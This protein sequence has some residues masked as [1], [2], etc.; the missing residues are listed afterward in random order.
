MKEETEM[1]EH[2]GIE[3]LLATYRD[4]GDADR[5]RVDRH[6][7]S[8][9]T[10]AARLASY[11][12]QDQDLARLADAHPSSRLRKDFYAAIGTRGEA[13]PQARVWSLAGQMAELAVVIL[14]IAVLGFVL[15]ERLH[16]M[17][18]PAAA[19]APEAA[20]PAVLQPS[21]APSAALPEV[22]P[23]APDYLAAP[24]KV[25]PAVE[26]QPAPVML[27]GNASVVTGTTATQAGEGQAYVVRLD[28]SLWKLAEKYLGD[29]NRYGEIVQAT[30]AKHAEDASFASVE[31]P[32]VIQP[33]SKLWIP[34]AGAQ[35]APVAV[36]AA[37]PAVPP[38]AAP[39][40]KP[41]G[42]P[43]LATGPAGQIAFGFWNNSSERC[44][45]EIDVI[46]VP[47]CLA[48]PGQCQQTRRIFTLN[49]VSEPA[50][51]PGGDR[52]A[53]RAWGK[54]P[55]DSPYANCAPPVSVRHLA[56]STLDG[57]DFRNLSGFF[58]DGHPNWSPDGQR[59]IFDSGRNK[60]DNI[61]RVYVVNSDGTNEQDLRIAGQYPAWAP[62]SQRFVYR[63]CDVTGNRCGV[64]MANAT[65][66]MPWNTGINLIAP[67][68]QDE[69]AAHPAWSLTG[70][71][72]VYQSSKA[73]S[74]DLYVVK[75]DG[76]GLRQ[77]TADP[78]IEGLPAWSPDSQWVAY[79]SN[80]NGQW[81]IWI[82]RADGSE[83]HLLFAFDGGI[84]GPTS[85]VEPYGQR[86]WIDEQVSWSR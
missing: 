43:A 47:A 76:T 84:F 28:D 53:F 68:V 26:G 23:A 12:E 3:G 61:I 74:W 8:C 18:L 70:D 5:Q 38:S 54:L 49:N 42:G 33:G 45:F 41:A 19:P 83:R 85:A 36:A 1:K 71:Q 52:L 24:V 30:R 82:I 22:A 34:A 80:A 56:S 44:T 79:L 25:P 67:V 78:G 27:Q 65:P 15:R 37:T 29:G 31:N 50:L 7:Q 14:L 81:G 9:A 73:G 72:I 75:A 77:L 4:L 16:S 55:D 20:L 58:E 46:N 63:G 39:A 60:E 57:T 21:S 6:V 51:S 86:D 40:A 32:N 35:P 10:C 66:S 48:G 69:K 17:A 11:R 62:D 59:I 2:E 13:A 64:W